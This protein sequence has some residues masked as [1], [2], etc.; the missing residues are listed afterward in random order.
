MTDL[1][2]YVPSTLSLIF[3]GSS[4]PRGRGSSE[5]LTYCHTLGVPRPSDATFPAFSCLPTSNRLIPSPQLDI[6]EGDPTDHDGVVSFFDLWSTLSLS[7]DPVNKGVLV[8][9]LPTSK[10]PYIRDHGWPMSRRLES[11]MTRRCGE[12]FCWTGRI[13]GRNF[14]SFARTVGKAARRR[15]IL[16]RQPCTPPSAKCLSVHCTLF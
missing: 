15:I 4:S 5:A 10:V 16:P 8:H 6:V 12:L 11:E 13:F 9:I 7:H 3:V 2:E 14:T 1:G